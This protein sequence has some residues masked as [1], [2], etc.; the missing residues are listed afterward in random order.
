[1]VVNVGSQAK[2]QVDTD[3]DSVTVAT[4]ESRAT[5]ALAF[6]SRGLPFWETAQHGRARRVLTLSLTTSSSSIFAVMA[7]AAEPRRSQRERKQAQHFV[8]G[9]LMLSNAGH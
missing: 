7:D 4:R 8:S 1:M 5:D 3:T 6:V 9:K 2:V